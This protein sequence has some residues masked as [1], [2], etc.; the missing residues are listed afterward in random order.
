MSTWSLI[1][2]HALHL[3]DRVL[4]GRV[5]AGGDPAG[6]RALLADG[7]DDLAGVDVVDGGH[8]LV[9]EP[10]GDVVGQL[11]GDRRAGLD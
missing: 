3:F 4:G 1:G 7:G 11:A 2:S 5:R 6:H 8:V 9:G 10:L